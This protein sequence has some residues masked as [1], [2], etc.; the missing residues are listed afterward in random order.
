M[1]ST[2]RLRW[3][4]T[5]WVIEQSVGRQNR[6]STA[7]FEIRELSGLREKATTSPL[8]LDVKNQSSQFY[9]FAGQ[10]IGRSG[11]VFKGRMCSEPCPLRGRI[12]TFD[13]DRFVR[14]HL[15]HKKPAVG[16]VV[17]DAVDLAGS[18]A[19]DQIGGDKVRKGDGRRVADSKGC[20][21]QRPA[22]RAP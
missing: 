7:R 13:Q 21:T 10:H 4:A 9:A 16:R 14:L 20:I 6:G 22:D 17:F 19:I 8:D 11:R 5:G 1:V 2:R 12:V 18:I 3:L 15:R